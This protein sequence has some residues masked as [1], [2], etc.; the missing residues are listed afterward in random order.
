MCSV[1]D[2]QGTAKDNLWQL[3]E[4]KTEL[5]ERCPGSTFRE[6]NYPN[7]VKDDGAHVHNI[8]I[9]VLKP[10]RGETAAGQGL[11]VFARPFE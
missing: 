4:D 5:G 7:L 10:G 3:L 6:E 11:E 2:G 8:H 9:R 1:R